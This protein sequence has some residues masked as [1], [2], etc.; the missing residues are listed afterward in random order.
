MGQLEGQILLA[1]VH[2]QHRNDR[3]AGL[4]DSGTFEWV[5]LTL[6]QREK[7]SSGLDPNL[8]I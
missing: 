5:V 4:L 1:I 7:E 3:G 8:K 6:V 2:L